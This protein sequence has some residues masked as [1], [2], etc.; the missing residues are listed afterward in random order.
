MCGSNNKYAPGGE[1]RNL[2]VLYPVFALV[3][4]WVLGAEHVLSN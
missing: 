4:L 1:M 3:S 2:D